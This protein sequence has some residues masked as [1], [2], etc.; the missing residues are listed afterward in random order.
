MAGLTD[1]SY[2]EIMKLILPPKALATVVAATAALTLSACTVNNNAA[3]AASSSAS[4]T[5]DEGMMGNETK[6]S[7][8]DIMFLQMMIP[9]HEQ[10]IEMS[11]LAMTNT[12]NVEV[13]ALAARIQAEQ[14]PEIAT[15][16]KL[17]TDAGQP[18]M[19][20]HIM[21]D[22]G[23]MSG[24]DM[25]ALKTAKDTEFDVMYLSGM[26]DHHN[27]AIT[28]ADGVSES[29]NYDVSFLANNI[30]NSQSAEIEEMTK[31]LAATS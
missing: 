28:M 24:D 3:P 1:L 18:L 5:M 15:M 27:G 14:Q 17:L 25:D 2:R 20:D 16:K 11:K 22:N 4:G 21:G 10:A 12:K 19:S 9:H 31:L 26:I 29:E 13:L 6:L 7:A 23:M 30:I 8:A